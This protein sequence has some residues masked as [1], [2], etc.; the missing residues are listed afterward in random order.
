MGLFSGV[1]KFFGNLFGG[2]DEEEKRRK[3]QQQSQ[4]QN[5]WRA[6]QKAPT[7][8]F[9]APANQ[10]QSR[11]PN[12][13]PASPQPVNGLNLALPGMT[14]NTPTGFPELLKKATPAD[15]RSQG[16][17]KIDQYIEQEKPRALEEE[18]KRTSWFDR[19]VTDRDWD[20]RAE[21][22]ARSRAVTR[23]QEENGYNKQPEVMLNLEKNRKTGD[24]LVEN[25]RKAGERLDKFGKGMDKVAQVAQYVPV[26]GSVLN[27]G[28][29]GAERANVGG[30]KDDIANQRMKNEFGMTKAEFDALDP[31]TQAKLH[32]IRNISYGLAPLDVLGFT[33][34][35]KS[36]A[37][38][39]GKSAAVQFAKEGAVDTVTKQAVKSA[40]K[41]EAT[42]FAVPAAIGTGISMAGQQYL[43]GDIDPLEAIKNGTIVGGTSLLFNQGGSLRKAVKAEQMADDIPGVKSVNPSRE[44]DAV[45]QTEAKVASELEAQRTAA[46][47]LD[48]PAYQRTGLKKAVATADNAATEKA[49]VEAG[50]GPSALDR[51]A[52]QHVEDIK[53]VIQ[54]G[55]D[56][57]NAYVSEHPEATQPEIEAAKA[58]IQKQVIDQIEQLKAARANE[59]V[60][61]SPEAQ[62]AT[63]RQIQTQPV[64]TAP[65]AASPGTVPSIP[66]FPQ[67]VASPTPNIPDVQPSQTPVVNNAPT[68]PQ[69][70]ANVNPNQPY[71]PALPD[72]DAAQAPAAPRLREAYLRQLGNADDTIPADA[73][74]RDVLVLDELRKRA[75]GQIANAADEDLVGMYD[76]PATDLPT[77]V[78]TPQDYAMA[79]AAVKRLYTMAKDGD[80]R[81]AN[82]AS[83]LYDAMEFGSANSAQYLRVTQRAFNDMPIPMKINKVIRHLEKLAAKAYGADDPRADFSDPA[84]RA[85]I[86]AQFD[87][88]FS[89]DQNIREAIS[90]AD[91]VLDE[92]RANPGAVSREAIDQAGAAKAAAEADLQVNN[93]R[94]AKV[95]D[96]LAPSN[97]DGYDKL[98]DYQR[99][100]MLSA[101]TGRVNDVA[102]TTGLN[103]PR[104]MI[105]MGVEGL[106]GRGANALRKA[107]G[108]T[109]GK[110]VQNGASVKDVVKA[111][112]GALRKTRDDFRGVTPIDSI[113]GVVKGSR[114]AADRT[115]LT[116]ASKGKFTRLVKASTNFATHITEGIADAEVTRRAKQEGIQKGFKGADLDNYVA[117][118]QYKPTAKME[119]QAKLVHETLNNLNDNPITNGMRAIGNAAE[120]HFGKPGKIIKNAVMPFPTWVGG[121]I[122]NSVTDRNVIANTIKMVNAMRKGDSEVAMRNAS[123]A[124]AGAGEAYAA[125]F[126]LA[127]EGYLSDTDANG[128]SYEGLYLHVGDR[129]IPIGSLGNFAPNIILGKATHDAMNGEGDPAENITNS[130]VKNLQAAFK[131][132]SVTT[133]T[134]GDNYLSKGVQQFGNNAAQGTSTLATGFFGQLIPTAVRDVNAVLDN[135]TDLNPTREKAET[136]IKKED[137]KTD[138]WKTSLNKMQDRIPVASQ[139]LE[140]K[141]DVAAPDLL[142]RTTRGNRDTPGGKEA[143]AE[144]KKVEDRKK[145]FEAR[146][147][148]DPKGERFEDAVQTRFE[149][150]K[151][152]DAI[153]GLQAKLAD[154]EADKNVSDKSKKET[155]DKIALMQ[156]H[157]AGKYDPKIADLYKS[158]SLEEWRN[159]GDPDSDEYDA[160]KYQM[161]FEYDQARANAGISKDDDDKGKGA[162]YAKKKKSGSGG[163][164]GGGSSEANRELARIKSNTLGSAPTPGT[165]SYGNL[166]PEKLS[167]APIPTVAKLRAKDL[168]KKRTIKV[169]KA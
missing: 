87:E 41:K 150:G 20:K 10:N 61:A 149:D 13:A 55:D 73:P 77:L 57:L 70:A 18:K 168:V 12:Q 83:N 66:E 112:P 4:Q 162:Y 88:V 94:F 9:N 1:S 79:E 159:L 74:N 48:T 153:E 146:G 99:T 60:A 82:V 139:Q 169:S 81:A 111:V 100:A 130:A 16:Q 56:E 39:A 97:R 133:L 6:P 132:L 126:I 136:N 91:A 65:S 22:S 27:L 46:Q 69:S 84:R 142:D 144:T 123:R 75:E 21:M 36:E 129:Y 53:A 85:T 90:K 68:V 43:T 122:W 161:L 89:T 17:K 134:G 76:V 101:P 54:Q 165:F 8:S 44:A 35:A 59:A 163:G 157:K 158:I 50:A 119:A 95:Y 160:D 121:N 33:G 147:I 62:S 7:T 52:F 135:Q 40:L 26:T 151:F 152:D 93:Q 145:D 92:A 19:T 131:G 98:A 5:Q 15:T 154:Q 128:D 49:A 34:L 148:P 156:V 115:D 104:E 71:A 38:A 110:Y 107:T 47:D 29:A 63:P 11:Q 86:N 124:L 108:K 109:P 113:E 64:P 138:W 164:S 137:G 116:G 106:M 102:I 45:A 72:V 118:T 117:A 103:L 80:T 155:Q 31:A 141:K 140:R 120:Q 23:Y 78:R 51:P 166:R 3:Q 25:S 24:A 96:D 105:N 143:R 32:N 125:G 127:K 14:P 167:G 2:D 114:Q 28:L 37:V 67:P 58:D 30:M 42:K